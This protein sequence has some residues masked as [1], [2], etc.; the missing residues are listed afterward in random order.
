MQSVSTNNMKYLQNQFH[1]EFKH[2]NGWLNKRKENAFKSS[3]IK[4]EITVCYRAT[5][6]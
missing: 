5:W 3:Q 2:M 6:A 4:L 1:I